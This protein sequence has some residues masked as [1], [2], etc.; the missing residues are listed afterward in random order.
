[1]KLIPRFGS[2]E[3]I[4]AMVVLWFQQL[5]MEFVWMS[6]IGRCI[7]GIPAPVSMGTVLI[8][9][10]YLPRT[11]TKWVSFEQVLQIRFTF[12]PSGTTPKS[13]RKS[14]L[15]SLPNSGYICLALDELDLHRW[16]WCL[17]SWLYWKIQV[18]SLWYLVWWRLSCFKHCEEVSWWLSFMTLSIVLYSEEHNISETVPI[19][20]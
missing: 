19:L 4:K 3:D 7:C 14:T 2:D 15:S 8:A 12:W 20:R 5:P 13:N 9:C 6:S 10:T 1:M 11:I 18:L 17:I 16:M